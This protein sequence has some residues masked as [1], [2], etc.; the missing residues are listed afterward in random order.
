M[1]SNTIKVWP[2]NIK[3]IKFIIN[4]KMCFKIFFYYAQINISQTFNLQEQKKTFNLQ[5]KNFQS[6][7]T[8]I[9][10]FNL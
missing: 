9:N 6:L 3:K 4:D 2:Y 8:K 10:A 1:N 7:W 5:K